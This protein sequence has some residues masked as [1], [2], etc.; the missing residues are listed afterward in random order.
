M[1]TYPWIS[2]VASAGS[3]AGLCLALIAP[4]GFGQPAIPPAYGRHTNLAEKDFAEAKSFSARDRLVGTY[5]FYWY[6]VQSGEHIRN[7]DG[8]DALTDHPASLAGFSYRSVA[9]HKKELLDMMAAG[10]DLA[11]P[12]FWGAP[13]EQSTNTGLHWS[14]VGLEKLVLAREELLH[15]GK[16]PPRLGLFYDTS[17]LQYNRWGQRLDLTTEYGQRWFYATVRDFFSM[18]PPKHWAMIEGRPIV[19][20]YAAAFAKNHDQK[21]IDYTKERF[22][23]DFGGRVPWIAA[24]VSW[25]VKADSRVAW[26][27]ALGLRNPGVAALGPGYDHSA[28]PGRTPLIV[29]REG[30]KFYEENWLKFLRRPANFVMVETWNEYHEGTDAAES[31]EYGRQY[32]ELT[33]KYADLFKQG[34]KP[35]PPRGAYTDAPSVCVTLG[36]Q[37]QEAGL[38]LLDNEDGRTVPATVE[39]Q[40]CR[41]IQPAPNLG[42]YVYFGVDDSFKSAEPATY[43]LVVEYF[44]AAPGTLVVEFDGS[45]PNAPFNGAYSSAPEVVK[46]AGSKTWKA[47]EFTLKEARFLNAQNRGADLRLVLTAPEFQARKVTLRRTKS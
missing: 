33:R 32:I 6:C 19:L 29:K 3:L 11:L 20:L 46:L 47:A 26:G 40:E 41:A 7:G 12:V 4:G 9:W 36:R 37:N 21:F 44:E 27:G 31:K 23:K 25:R 8:T 16:N 15:E 38:R 34:W 10:I 39:G 17:T 35:V 18:V 1:P 13:S 28:V 14:Y 30:G 43:K 42:R 45:D 5:Y 24:E 22:A 2:S